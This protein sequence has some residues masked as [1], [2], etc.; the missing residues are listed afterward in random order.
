MNEM[1]YNEFQC[2]NVNY[3]SINCLTSLH[4]HADKYYAINPQIKSISKQNR[5]H[6]LNTDALLHEVLPSGIIVDSGSTTHVFKKA[7]YFIN[8]DRNFDPSQYTVMLASGNV[9]DK[10]LGRGTVEIKLLDCDNQCKVV[11]LL[12]ALYMPSLNHEGL[13]STKQCLAQQ[14]AQFWLDTG[15][16]YMIIEGAKIP[17]RDDKPLHYVN[18]I[19]ER[20]H[21]SRR[22]L[23]VWHQILGHPHPKAVMLIEKVVEGMSITG[24]KKAK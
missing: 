5:I 22:P 2:N 19:N 9:S 20:L 15:D 7:H 6:Q 12:N 8:W 4:T 3:F 21:T 17:L 11:R 14:G 18:M 10:I 13:I 16:S 1:Y 23:E 24:D